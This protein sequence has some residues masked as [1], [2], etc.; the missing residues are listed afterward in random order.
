MTVN[1]QVENAADL[2]AASPLRIKYDPAQL[3]LNDMASGDI[4]TRDGA[5]S[6]SQKDIRN[7]SGEATLTV[8]RVPGS[9]GVA[10][11]GALAALNFIAVG[12]APALSPSSTPD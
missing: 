4:F 5:R 12:Q 8:T 10:G 1:L 3:R 6:V 2:F 7:D 11:S 9:S